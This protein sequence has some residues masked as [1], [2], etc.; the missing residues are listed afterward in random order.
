M[1]A[2]VKGSVSLPYYNSFLGSASLFGVRCCSDPSICHGRG[3]QIG[4]AWSLQDGSNAHATANAQ[5]D[6]AVARLLA[7]EFVQQLDD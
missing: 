6:Q 1:I 3:V 7:L 5:R 4:L 2:Y